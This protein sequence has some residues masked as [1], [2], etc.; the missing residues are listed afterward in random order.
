[1]KINKLPTDKQGFI[2]C[3][4]DSVKLPTNKGVNLPYVLL[5]K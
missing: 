2:I 5:I 4:G 3:I 1:M